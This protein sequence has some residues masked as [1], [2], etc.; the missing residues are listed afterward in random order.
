[1]ISMILLML[2]AVQVASQAQ[3]RSEQCNLESERSGRP[4][5]RT[6]EREIATVNRS[7]L[8]ARPAA[9][10]METTNRVRG[11]VCDERRYRGQRQHALGPHRSRRP[12][13]L[14]VAGATIRP[15]PDRPRVPPAGFYSARFPRELNSL[16]WRL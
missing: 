13:G 16:R 12:S 2:H 8:R 11:A 4:A 15:L 1:M 14:K 9:R 7:V 5:P 10:F 6:P 3:E